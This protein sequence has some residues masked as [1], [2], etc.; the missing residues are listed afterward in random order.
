MVHHVSAAD[1]AD[2]QKNKKGRTKEDIASHVLSMR[3][4]LQEELSDLELLLLRR[5]HILVFSVSAHAAVLTATHLPISSL[6]VFP[7]PLLLSF[8][9]LPPR[10]R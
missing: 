7:A 9:K 3:P 4:D 1:L 10:V 5:G 2:P 6:V 8:A